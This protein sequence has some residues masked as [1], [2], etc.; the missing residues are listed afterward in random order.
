MLQ[1]LS[2]CPYRDSS[3]YLFTRLS[4]MNVWPLSSTGFYYMLN[5]S[6]LPVI[7]LFFTV[8]NPTIN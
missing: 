6:Y 7:Q 2:E 4:I 8:N 5:F 1:G 3:M